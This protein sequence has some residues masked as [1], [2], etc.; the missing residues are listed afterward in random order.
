MQNKYKNASLGSNDVTQLAGCQA[1]K[2]EGGFVMTFLLQ[3]DK[4]LL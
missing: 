1:V 2:K 3:N 4:F